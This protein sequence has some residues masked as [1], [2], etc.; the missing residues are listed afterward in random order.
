TSSM[1][2]PTPAIQWP[3]GPGNGPM[4]GCAKPITCSP[5]R[6]GKA[7]SFNTCSPDLL[8][9]VQEPVSSTTNRIE[10]GVNAPLRQM[11]SLH[12][13]MRLDRRKRAVE[14]WLH[15][16]TEAPVPVHTFIQPQHY[17]PTARSK[18]T[19]HEPIGP[20]LYDR[21][22]STEEGMGIQRGWKGL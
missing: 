12:R 9:E 5:P 2:K 4:T 18:T 6:P 19:M 10:G 13:G 16:H 20:A 15:Q 1:R 17:D 14:W 8:A 3:P 11:L 7:R 22:F 21:G